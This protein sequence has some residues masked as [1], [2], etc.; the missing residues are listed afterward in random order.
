M[1]RLT[2]SQRILIH[3]SLF[4]RFREEYECPVEVTQMG[5]SSILRLSR[6]HVALELKKLIQDERA[7]SRLAHVEGAKSRR[8]AYFLTYQGEKVAA[9]MRMKA[10]DSAARWIDPEGNP[11]EGAGEEL[12]RL[13]R[14]LERPLTPVYESILSGE[15]V[16][17]RAEARPPP[18]AG[19]RDLVG[20]SG[21]LRKLQNWYSEGPPVLLLTGLPGIGKTTLARAFFEEVEGGMWFKVF[22]FH[23]ASSLLST[24]AQGMAAQGRRRLLSYLKSNPVDYGEAGLLLSSEASE[25]LLVFDDVSASPSASQVLRLFLEY[26]APGCKLLLTA[27]DRPEFLRAEDLLEDRLSEIHLQGLSM[28]E[29]RDLLRRF[30]G[31]HEEV[32]SIHELTG[33]H[34]LLLRLFS[35]TSARPRIQDAETILLDEV[36]RG[37]G[38]TEESILLQASVFRKA[39]P[40]NAVGTLSVR[41]LRSLVRKGLL[42]E[43]GGKYEVH[44]ILAP[45]VRRHG[46]EAVRDAHARASMFWKSQSEWLEALHHMAATGE[47]RE[48]LLLAKE[49]LDEVL[50]RG[51]A[52]ELL[53]ILEGLSDEGG[54]TLRYLRC[55][56]LDYLGQ[57]TQ[58]L[59]GL[60]EGLREA[61]K[62][63]RVPFLLLRGRIHSKRGEFKEAEEAFEAAASLSEGQGMELNLGMALYGLG[64]VQRKMGRM[65]EALAYMRRALEIFDVVK[66]ER[67]GGRARM[68]V[69]IIQLQAGRPEEAVEWFQRSMPI[70][71]ARKED[72]AYLHNN[73]GI[74][75]SKLSRPQEALMAFEESV[76][77]AEEAGMVRAQG[78]ALANA[79]DLYIDFGQLDRALEYCEKSLHIFGRLRDPVMISACHANRAKAER[80]RGRLREAERL[81]RESLRALEGTRAPYSLAARWLE[82]SDLYEEM[83]EEK[84][85]H[86]Y[87]SKALN[88]LREDR[89]S[90]S[91]MEP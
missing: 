48:L 50:E 74:A 51:Q 52:S 36:L 13:S 39:F 18:P 25:T 17:L 23:S 45:L 24:V 42:A 14:S 76:R 35:S 38:A 47:T 70:L 64:I 29:S 28:E 86:E 65:E 72:S 60:E 37:L 31:P 53:D 19:T 4:S 3:L 69:G 82:I 46:G 32:E 27:R 44:D 8:K 5:I 7:E 77:L 71:S 89:R 58:A 67:E 56:A 2:V 62:A 85:A 75:H 68:E 63:E 55:R 16:D 80:A 22:P 12:L 1:S 26:P 87:R 66:A 84:E 81:Y 49:K 90:L 40:R 15:L 83:G 88:V 57:W 21:E 61:S 10:R 11:L 54:A 78:Y 91:S 41:A 43:N 6:S 30:G 9:S 20:R 33:G 59:V 73:L 34:P 79:S